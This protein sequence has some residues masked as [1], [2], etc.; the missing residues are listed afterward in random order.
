MGSCRT[1]NLHLTH[2]TECYKDVRMLFAHA[3]ISN[4]RDKGT[5]TGEKVQ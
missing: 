5:A 4:C 2:L 3:E 1:I